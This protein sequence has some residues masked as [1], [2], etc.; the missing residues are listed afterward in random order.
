MTSVGEVTHPNVDQLLIMQC[1]KLLV[2]IN[3]IKP[4]TYFEDDIIKTDKWERFYIKWYSDISKDV[5]KQIPQTTQL[6]NQCPNIQLAMF[7]VMKPGTIVY[8][9]RG[10]NRGSL[11]VQRPS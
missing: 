8:P 11:R 5:A 10:P 4:E 2:N 6:L 3:T 7:S 1:L 9:H